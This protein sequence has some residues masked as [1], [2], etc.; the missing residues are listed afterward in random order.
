MKSTAQIY[1]E[2]TNIPQELQAACN[3]VNSVNIV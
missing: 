1:E 3:I 2:S